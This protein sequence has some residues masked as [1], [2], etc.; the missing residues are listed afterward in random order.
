MTSPRKSSKAVIPQISL[1]REFHKQLRQDDDA[2]DDEPNGFYA[3]K[4]V[5]CFSNSMNQLGLIVTSV[6]CMLVF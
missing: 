2:Q 6:V 1:F 3:G 4:L 5:Q